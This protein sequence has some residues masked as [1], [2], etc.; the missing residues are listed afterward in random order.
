L[1]PASAASLRGEKHSDEIT[2]R[3]ETLSNMRFEHPVSSSDT[4]R[5]NI[6][7]KNRAM[8]TGQKLAKEGLLRRVNSLFY[9]GRRVTKRG[10]SS[11]QSISREA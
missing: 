11:Y 3:K 1:R 10:K 5:S 2:A 9:F 6:A 8:D 7:E 4:S